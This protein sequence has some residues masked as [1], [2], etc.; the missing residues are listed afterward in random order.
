[1]EQNANQKNNLTSIETKILNGEVSKLSNDQRIFYEYLQEQRKQRD[2]NIPLDKYFELFSSD[3]VL[4]EYDLS[5]DEI[6]SGIV[7]GGL[8]GGIDGIF[9]FI[10]GKLVTDADS[11]SYPKQNVIVSVNII[12]SKTTESY[13]ADVINRFNSNAVDLFNLD[14][15]IEEL[16]T[17]YNTNLLQIISNFRT[18]YT[19]LVSYFPTIE[20]NYYYATF[21]KTIPEI[22]SWLDSSK[23]KLENVI[24]DLFKGCCYSFTFLGAREL[25]EL[26]KKTRPGALTLQLVEAPI[27]TENGSCICLVNLVDY[28]RLITFDYS[29]C[30]NIELRRGIFEANVRDYEGDVDVNKAIKG[31]LDTPIIGEDFWW[32]NN[33]IAAVVSKVA[34]TGKKLTVEDLQ[35]VNGLQTSIEIFEHFSNLYNEGNEIKDS[36]NILVRIIQCS[37]ESRNHIIKATNYQTKISTASLRA[38][39]PMQEKIEEYFKTCGYYYERRKNFYKNQNKPRERI[40]S[41]TYLAQAVTAIALG[42]PN[43]AKGRPSSLLGDDSGY[44]RVFNEDYPFD[45][46]NTCIEVI[47][48]IEEYLSINDSADYSGGIN[49]KY[50][51]A[52]FA[53]AITTGIPVFK[54][55]LVN[56]IKIEK[57]NDAL[58][59]DCLKEIKTIYEEFRTQGFAEYR[60]LKDPNFDKS[61]KN[62]ISELTKKQ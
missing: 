14:K 4:K 25:Y 28:F 61:L 19:K 13:E 26:A 36:R 48:K 51:L 43:N 56:R 18:V 44:K 46:Y 8:D 32:L 45:L 1:M 31:T 38:T 50:H 29:D 17:H 52:M 62:R 41:I 6:Q 49:I 24:R 58:L 9:I 35:I 57:Y 27:P 16:T 55:N 23:Q 15:P 34:Q 3:M 33:G 40:I 5:D 2:P 42:E 60:I 20:F 7:G 11:F 12:Q 10:N 21:S 47:K 22:D 37:E 54:P 30:K 53:T 59:G 39:D